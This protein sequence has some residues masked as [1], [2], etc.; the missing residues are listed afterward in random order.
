MQ[1]GEGGS[2]AAFLRRKF[3]EDVE[4][5]DLAI[6]KY[7]KFFDH[8]GAIDSP[9]K[10]QQAIVLA[11][12]QGFSGEIAEMTSMK[13]LIE[14]RRSGRDLTPDAG[15]VSADI[16]RV[17]GSAS[18]VAVGREIKKENLTYEFGAS[19]AKQ[20]LEMEEAMMKLAR[21]VAPTVITAMDGFGTAVTS[22]TG[23]IGSLGTG[24]RQMQESRIYRMFF[25]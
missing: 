2:S 25:D 24:I 20:T 11:Q 21:E 6:G 22:L 23:L 9:E 5:S 15:E 3:T 19:F 1:R 12:S 13:R 4:T 18:A 8:F 7:E 17:E 14:K 16:A 10:M